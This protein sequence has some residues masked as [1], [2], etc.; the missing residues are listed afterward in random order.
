M[1][2]AQMRRVRFRKATK[3]ASCDSA[4][5]GAAILTGEYREAAVDGSFFGASGAS[6]GADVSAA[7]S[8]G[9]VAC[10]L[11]EDTGSWSFVASISL[12][13]FGLY[14]HHLALGRLWRRFLD[15]LAIR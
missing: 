8:V 15:F 2:M 3:S 13:P 10:D 4:V 5:C 12:P 7:G 14:C 1:A 9:D 11:F 6:M